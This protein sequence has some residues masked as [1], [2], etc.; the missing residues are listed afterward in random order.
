MVDGF[1]AQIH[2]LP[3]VPLN[4][5]AREKMPEYVLKLR[6]KSAAWLPALFPAKRIQRQGAVRLLIALIQLLD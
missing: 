4:E 3:C 1:L 2:R 5:V 6:Q